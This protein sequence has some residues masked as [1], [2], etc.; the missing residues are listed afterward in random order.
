MSSSTKIKMLSEVDLIGGCLL[1]IVALAIGLLVV[2]VS[3]PAFIG[4]LGLHVDETYPDKN[5][6]CVVMKEGK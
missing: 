4:Q 1:L 3:N 2:W 6:E 5:V